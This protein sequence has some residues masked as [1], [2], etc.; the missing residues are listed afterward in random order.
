MNTY[1]TKWPECI[2]N[3]RWGGGTR[4][5]RALL[6]AGLAL[7]PAG[8]RADC[9]GHPDRISALLGSHHLHAIAPLN[10]R[11]PGA[12]L[13]WNCGEVDVTAG[14]YE[15]SYENV[16]V[17]AMV[18]YPVVVKPWLEMGP[19]AG[20]ARYP[21]YADWQVVH[22]GDLVPI[23][24]FQIRVANAFMK[25]MPGDMETVTAVLAFGLTFQIGAKD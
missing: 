1:G 22:Y 5:L 25:V 11:N 3:T 4:W 13:T 2:S 23:G 24:G 21:E 19:F 10:E 6:I 20:V 8:A 7:T 18:T 14:A 15:N 16:S 9:D 12:F 17:A